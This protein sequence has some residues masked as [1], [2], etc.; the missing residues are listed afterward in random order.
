MKRESAEKE[1]DWNIPYVNAAWNCVTVLYNT[2][3]NIANGKY[4]V[5][6][7]NS[8]GQAVSKA[9]LIPNGTINFDMSKQIAGLYI[10]VLTKNGTKIDYRN[11][12]WAK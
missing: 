1:R 8:S 3:D 6:L 11:V 2:T 12:V 10:A 5:T 9:N 4:E 7:Y